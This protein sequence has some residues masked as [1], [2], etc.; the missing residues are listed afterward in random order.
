M[1]IK[2]VC[3]F[4]VYYNLGLDISLLWVDGTLLL[5]SLILLWYIV[6]MRAPTHIRGKPLKNINYYSSKTRGGKKKTNRSFDVII[7]YLGVNQKF[8]LFIY[9]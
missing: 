4:H 8:V 3:A 1:S 9:Q 2:S 5:C 7:M 6:I